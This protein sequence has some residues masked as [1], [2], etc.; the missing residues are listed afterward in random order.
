MKD[1]VPALAA[2][3]KQGVD[4]NARNPGS[5]TLLEM[6]T[7]RRRPRA[8]EYL[9][10]EGAFMDESTL[11]ITGGAGGGGEQGSRVEPAKKEGAKEGDGA[12]AAGEGTPKSGKALEKLAFRAVMKDDVPALAALLKQGVD[13][14]ARNPGSHTLLEMAT[15]RRR[16]RAAEYLQSEGAFMD[17]STLS[18]TS[19]GS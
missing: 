18:I 12:D 11:S 1:D 7:E 5:H 16:P 2:L 17:E 19:G 9:Q 8:A 13:I 6:A 14:N 4:I 3:L 10:S 15:E